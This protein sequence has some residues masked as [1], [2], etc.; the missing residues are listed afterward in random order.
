VCGEE[1]PPV[2]PLSLFPTVSDP[3]GSFADMCILLIL[4][5]LVNNQLSILPKKDE[6]GI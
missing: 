5:M 3:A 6:H 4:S 1:A 2:P